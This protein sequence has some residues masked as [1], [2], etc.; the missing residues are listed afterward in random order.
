MARLNPPHPTRN[1][2]R[3][4]E[5]GTVPAAGLRFCCIGGRQKVKQQSVGLGRITD[6]VVGQNEFAQHPVVAGTRRYRLV[7]ETGRF[8]IGI[9]IKG[10]LRK[11]SLP[12]PEPGA[13]NLVRIGFASDGIRQPGCAAG[14]SGAF[15]PEKRVTARSKLPQKKWT[16]LALPK[17][18]VR[19]SLKM[20]STWISARQK[21]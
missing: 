6:G 21:L 11:A 17:K 20:R 16:G 4:F 18:P 14:M 12:G 5:R 9:G 10:S 19:N 3:A 1:A 2:D 8:G 13:A 7:A 15:R